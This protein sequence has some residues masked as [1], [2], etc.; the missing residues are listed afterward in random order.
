MECQKNT[1]NKMRHEKHT[2]ENKTDKTGKEIGTTYCLGSKDCTHNFK[3]EE[4][5]MKNK[6]LREKSRCI[7]CRC[8]KARLLKQKHKN[9]M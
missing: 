5:K 4:V 7:V 6:V 2:F 1:A 3:L 9:K 8:S